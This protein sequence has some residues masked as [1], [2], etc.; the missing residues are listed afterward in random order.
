MNLALVVD[1]FHQL[2]A[3]FDDFSGQSSLKVRINEFWTWRT[4]ILKFG[5]FLFIFRFY[6]N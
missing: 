5:E 6:L 4:R 2:G 1:Q 3:L